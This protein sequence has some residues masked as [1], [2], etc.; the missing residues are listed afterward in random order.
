MLNYIVSF[1]KQYVKLF[2]CMQIKLIV[3]VELEIDL[4]CE[5]LSNNR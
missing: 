2:N 5:K 1:P 3:G 4:I